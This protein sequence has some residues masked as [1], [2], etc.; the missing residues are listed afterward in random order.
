MKNKLYLATAVA[1]FFFLAGGSTPAI[2]QAQDI[3]EDMTEDIILTVTPEEAI[4]YQYDTSIDT[5]EEFLAES[6][7]IEE[8]EPAPQKFA[9]DQTDPAAE[10][11]MAEGLFFEDTEQ[12]MSEMLNKYGAPAA[13]EK[14]E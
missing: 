6:H 11:L 8:E 7:I 12:N 10:K 13:G 3:E 2:S 9:G 4:E 1:T 5:P 14:K